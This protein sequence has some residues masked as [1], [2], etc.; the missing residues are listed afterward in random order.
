M[1]TPSLEKLAVD[2]MRLANYCALS[3][4]HGI[5][6][7]FGADSKATC[8]QGAERASSWCQQD[9]IDAY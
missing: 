5:T 1:L 8:K 3:R 4:M 2:G 7:R 9:E 6:Q